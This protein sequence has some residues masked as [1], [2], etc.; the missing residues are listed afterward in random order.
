MKSFKFLL[1]FSLLAIFLMTLSPLSA[2]ARDGEDDDEDENELMEDDSD[3]DDSDDDDSDDDSNDSDD[4]DDKD[5]DEREIEI[6]L[7]EDEDE[8]K[9]D[10]D[11][12]DRIRER[13]EGDVKS[14]D[15]SDRYYLSVQWG[16]FPVEGEAKPTLESTSWD[17][18]VLFGEGEGS[19][20]A[21]PHK[22]IRFERGDQLDHIN[23]TTSTRFKTEFVSTILAGNDGVL[24]KIFANADDENTSI[25]FDTDYSSTDAEVTLATLIEKGTVEVNYSP[26]KVV[27]KLW[28]HEDWLEDRIEHKEEGKKHH[29]KDAVKGSWY[30]RY[31]DSAVD[32][33]FFHGYKDNRGQL[34][35]EI[36][37]GR[38]LTR[39]EV[40][41]VAYELGLK[42]DLGVGQETC[43]PKTVTTT[44]ATDWMGTH[45]ARPYVQCVE[46]TGTTLALLDEVVKESV[47]AGNESALRWEVVATVFQLLDAEYTGAAN[48]DLSDLASAT[49]A[50]TY[51]DMIDRAVELGIVA[52]Y[53]DGTFKPFK[54]VNRAEMFKMV[55]LSKEAFEF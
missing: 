32:N 41:K 55:S 45:W 4:D 30:E 53:S 42:L 23:W 26:Y 10:D 7:F 37:P 17:G 44:A 39:F 15:F 29:M 47:S 48:A 34:T 24:F 28:N 18:S 40:L 54:E 33:G 38:T 27:F 11:D 12:L 43:D 20:V 5:E 36:G 31:M 21:R 35:G 51:K 1:M 25:L 22:T 19:I 52:G 50:A 16:Y 2:F 13:L 3:D 46:N 9:I 8:G 49:L 6:D 14:Q